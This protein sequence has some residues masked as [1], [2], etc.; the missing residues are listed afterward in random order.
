M[1]SVYVKRDMLGENRR[2]KC[3]LFNIRNMMIVGSSRRF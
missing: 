3:F 2:S 1:E